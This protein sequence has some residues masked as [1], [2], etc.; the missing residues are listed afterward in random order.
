MTEVEKL[1]DYINRTQF[2][3]LSNE[4]IAS[5]KIR[6]LDSLGCAL[7]ALKSPVIEK[8]KTHIDDF[9][10]NPLCTLI[11]GG[12]TAPDRAALF[13][14]A[15]IRFLDFND[16]FLAKKETC[17]PSDN[18][19]AVLAA[20]EYAKISGKQFLLAMAL[21]YQVQCTLSEVAPVRDKGFD[22]T[23]EGVYGVVA[24]VSKALNLSA[25]QTANALAIA[26]VANN[27]LR[28]TRTGALSNWK[29]LAYPYTAFSGT[30]A[31]FLAYRGITGPLEIFEGN[32]GFMHSIS[33][34][35]EVEWTKKGLDIV[36]RT[37]IKKYNAEIHSQATIE[38]ALE[39]KTKYKIDPSEIQS[40]HIETF[41]VAFNII[42]GGEEG[43]KKV[44]RTKEEADHSLLYM[45]SVALIDGEVTPKQYEPQRIIQK[46][47]QTLLQKII[48]Q[49]RSDFSERFPKE[50]PSKIVIQMNDGKR[51]EIEKKDY[52]GF[53]T[54]PMT[55]ERALKKFNTLAGDRSEIPAII[56]QLEK[57]EISALT[58]AL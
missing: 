25:E 33:G 13:N 50:M 39:L 52:E 26:G 48:V 4:T 37:I 23:T 57:I 28:V 35:F 3:D 8:I 9:G 58:K 47:V 51:F 27:A 32:K 20:G 10:G 31:A 55:W 38:G 34:P 12:K 54:K 36:Q 53:L 43:T 2:T 29:G 5:L 18:N 45:V 49:P 15:L 1:A 21:A 17:H 42:G 44:I 11:G 46:D 24:G 40:I 16:S 6:L 22:H 30:N 14:S 56:E 41:D 7:G 19:G